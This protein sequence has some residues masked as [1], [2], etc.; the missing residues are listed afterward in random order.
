MKILLSLLLVMAVQF[1]N[2]QKTIW[3][4]Q[5]CIDAGLENS[6]AVKIQKLAVK[7][8]QK[9]RVSMLN[10]LLPTVSLFGS[11]SYNFG[12]T[13]DPGTNARVSSNIQFDNFYMNAQMNLLDFGAIATAQ[14]SKLDVELAEAEQ[15]IIENEYKQFYLLF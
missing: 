3:S 4:L 9:S 15:A 12:S 5:N 13:I 8:T 11:Q 6:I 14:K 10:E 7:R 1:A 2:G